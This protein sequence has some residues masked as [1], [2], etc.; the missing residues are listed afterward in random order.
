MR[1]SDFFTSVK[2]SQGGFF[3]GGREF[4]VTAAAVVDV[5]CVMSWAADARSSPKFGRLRH[6]ATTSKF[7][8]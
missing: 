3:R 6:A 8:F 7:R 5:G 1:K 2:N 4:N